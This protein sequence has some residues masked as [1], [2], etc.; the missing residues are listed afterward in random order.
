[1]DDTE[2]DLM[3]MRYLNVISRCQYIN[4][5]TFPFKCIMNNNKE[6]KDREGIAKQIAKM[7]DLIRKKSHFKNRQNRG[8]I[9][10]ILQLSVSLKQIVENIAN[11]ESQPIKKEITVVKDKNIKKRKLE[12]NEDVHDDDEDD[13]DDF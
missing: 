6:L 7:N 4:Y 11:D 2:K 1:M 12:E 10:K 9:E 5:T 13:N 8:S 3:S